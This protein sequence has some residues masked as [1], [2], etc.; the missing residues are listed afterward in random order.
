MLMPD[1]KV[2]SREEWTAARKGHLAKEKEL[3]RLR[4]QLSRERRELPWVRV[5]KTYVFDGPNGRETLADLFE[6][7]SQLI[8]QHFM[9]DPSW[10]EG[11][12]SC[13]FWADNFDGLGVHLNHRDVTM[14]LVSRAALQ[15][16]QAYRKRMGWTVKWV[17]SLDTDFNRDYHVSFTDEEREQGR[18]Y[19][20]YATGGF[21]VNEAPGISV[22]FKDPSGAVFHTYSCYARGLDML[23]TAYHLLDLVPKRLDEEGLPYGMAWLRHHDRYEDR[24]ISVA[25]G[26]RRPASRE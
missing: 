4:D 17:S 14:V 18:A 5:D 21:P 19:Y 24:V 22:F 16:L 20:N 7:R 2:V 26:L 1:R 11:C 15:T 6:G 12:K 10:D 13:S 23:N 25:G 3:T 9:F 8:V